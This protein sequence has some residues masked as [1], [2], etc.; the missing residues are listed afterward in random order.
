MKKPPSKK[1]RGKPK[2]AAT[3]RSH[4]KAKGTPTQT[5]FWESFKTKK[6]RE[7]K[8]KK[9]PKEESQILH[10]RK[11]LRKWPDRQKLVASDDLIALFLQKS[12]RGD[13]FMFT[14]KNTKEEAKRIKEKLKLK[15]K[16]KSS[17]SK[18]DKFKPELISLRQEGVTFEGLQLWL[19]EKRVKVEVSTISRWFKKYSG[20]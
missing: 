11:T 4:L 13:E 5:V 15:K 17:A 12:K 20:V 19:R 18:L 14:A 16:K 7:A 2:K 3:Q 6:G 9:A 1:E 10:G 8:L